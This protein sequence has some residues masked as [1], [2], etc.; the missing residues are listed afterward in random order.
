MKYVLVSKD[1]PWS[2]YLYTLLQKHVGDFVWFKDNSLLNL[3]DFL[4]QMNPEYVFFFH[5]SEIVIDPIYKKYKCVVIHTSNLPDGK[6]GSPLQN[7]IMDGVV[8]SKVNALEMK[9][10]VDS[11]GV[12]SSRPI[13]LQGS[14]SD[15]YFTI[16]D[17]SVN[18]ISDCIEGCVPIP[19]ITGGKKFKRNLNNEIDFTKD[20]KSINDFI[21]ML[22]GP[23]YPN[24]YLEIGNY[25]LSFTRSRLD[26][27]KSIIADIKITPK[28]D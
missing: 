27:N 2:D 7:Q 15:I 24:S 25:R 17:I 4:N 22:D 12:Y 21:R 5:W 11:G 13:T 8:Q 28:D 18:L 6:G 1:L 20:L 14:I 9:K 3:E 23:G 16:A 10:E 26:Y 19:Q